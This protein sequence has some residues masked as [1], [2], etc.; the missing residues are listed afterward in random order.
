MNRTV[1]IVKSPGK[2]RGWHAFSIHWDQ[3]EIVST[4]L[5]N[6][7][8]TW[9]AAWELVWQGHRSTIKQPHRLPDQCPEHWSFKTLREAIAHFEHNT[10]AVHNGKG[11]RIT[12]KG[13]PI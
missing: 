7:F 12:H 4:W 11:W 1:V 2:A 10:L 5:R 3:A 9:L 8:S 13:N 6:G